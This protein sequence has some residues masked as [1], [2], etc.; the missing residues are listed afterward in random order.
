MNICLITPGFA[1]GGAEVIA[2]NTANFYHSEGHKVLLISFGDRGPILK[3]LSGNVDILFV[4]PENYF[5]LSHA[6][7]NHRYFS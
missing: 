4:K 5:S 7:K 1:G 2:V 3:S 6:L